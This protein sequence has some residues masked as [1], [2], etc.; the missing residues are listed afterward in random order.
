V[1][2]TA[3]QIGA[4]QFTG[5]QEGRAVGAGSNKRRWLL[6]QALAN[7]RQP[8]RVTPT[9]EEV[10]EV[11]VQAQARTRL[12]LKPVPYVVTDLAPLVAAIAAKEREREMDEFRAL[13][14]AL[15]ADD[16]YEEAA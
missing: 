4:F 8:R 5:F 15:L 10:A 1:I 11:L 9:P 3:F 12:F 14:E 2:Q 16:D 13:V 6:A 7:M